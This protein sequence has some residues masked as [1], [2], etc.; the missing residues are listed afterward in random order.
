MLIDTHL[1]VNSTLV[2]INSMSIIGRPSSELFIFIYRPTNYNPQTKSASLT[3]VL[4][5]FLLCLYLFI[6]F[7]KSSNVWKIPNEGNIYR[8]FKLFKLQFSLYTIQ[9]CLS[10]NGA[11]HLQ[12]ATITFDILNAL[13]PSINNFFNTHPM[14]TANSWC[15]SDEHEH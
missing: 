6:N 4:F 5:C 8:S 9:M 14:Y 12:T 10:N 3:T 1:K 13:F 2:K 11:E 7:F 15:S